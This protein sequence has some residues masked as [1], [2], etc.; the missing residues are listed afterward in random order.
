MYG[1]VL[2][3]GALA[4]AQHDD[5]STAHE[6]LTEATGAARRLG[7]DANLRGTA[8]GPV[9]AQMHQVN[10]AVTLGDAGTAI[11]LARQI[12]PAAITITERKA[13]LLIDVAQAFFQWGK[14]GQAYTALRAAEQ[15]A[16]QELAARAPVRTLARNLAA[17]APPG[18]RRDAAYL[19]DRIGAY[20]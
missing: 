8:F 2:L 15:T 1:S 6:M 20:T 3:R 11:D 13:S 17:L 16:P 12:D 4:A 7:T 14:Y 18:T 9:N 19:A 5:R 10:V